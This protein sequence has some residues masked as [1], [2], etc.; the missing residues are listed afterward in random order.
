VIPGT[1]TEGI[2]VVNPPTDG[3]YLLS[4]EH[5]SGEFTVNLSTGTAVSGLPAIEKSGVL[6]TARL[7]SKGEVFLPEGIWK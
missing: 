5:P 6:R 2:A 3:Q 1:I 7:L 4:V